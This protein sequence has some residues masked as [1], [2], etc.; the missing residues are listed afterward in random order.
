MATI[1]FDPRMLL[2]PKAAAQRSSSPRDSDS[3]VGS[4]KRR[5]ASQS[6]LS[7]SGK[8]A[9]AS[10]SFARPAA[11]DDSSH[12]P[13]MA[14]MMETMYNVAER[15]DLPRK[16]PKLE[17]NGQKV[18]TDF[19]GG[20]GGIVS[21][22]LKDTTPNDTEEATGKDDLSHHFHSG[23]GLNQLGDL[24]EKINRASAGAAEVVDLSSEADD[25]EL[26]P[27]ET[28]GVVDLTKDDGE[29]SASNDPPSVCF[30][31]IDGARVN[32]YK[33]PRPSANAVDFANRTW[34]PIKCKLQRLHGPSMKITVYDAIGKDFG[35]LDV[36]ASVA[37]A[38]V[39]DAKLFKVRTEARLPKRSRKEWEMPG[40]TCSYV[41]DISI[42][43][44]GPLNHAEAVG[45]FLSQK[46]VFLKRPGY[47]YPSMDYFNPHDRTK[48]MA[49]RKVNAPGYRSTTITR[50]TEETQND[51]SNLF[52]SI[53]N[54]DDIPEA[55][56][57][58]NVIT[59]LLQH[60]KQALHF[61]RSHEEISPNEDGS[62]SSQLLKKI[63]RANGTTA[64]LNLITDREISQPPP[65]VRGGILADMMGL[66]K[67]LSLLALIASTTAQASEWV[68]HESLAKPRIRATLL[69]CPLSVVHNWE[70]QIAAHIKADSLTAYVYHGSNRSS[71]PS[72]F[73]SV[74]III[75][76]YGILA[77][78]MNSPNLR[79]R[80][81]NPFERY[82][83]YRMVL[84]EAH[85]I[86]EQGTR[87]SQA[88]CRV[89]SFCR[90]ALTGTPI[91]N[92]LDDFGSLLK[93]L[94]VSPFED[95]SNFSRYILAP[96]KNAD[97][98][99]LMRLR[100]LVGS[101]MLRRTKEKIDLPK[102]VERVVRLEFSKDE[103][104]LYDAFKR[105]GNNRLNALSS[106]SNKLAGKAYRQVLR[107]ILILRLISAHGRELLNDEDF[108]VLKG[109][110][111]STAIDLDSE[112]DSTK[113]LISDRDAYEMLSLHQQTGTD[114]CARCTKQ[115]QAKE[116]DEASVFGYILTCYQLICNE[117][118]ES[119]KK[120]MDE[121]KRDER[122]VCLYC[123]EPIRAYL[124][125]LT[126]EGLER[127]DDARAKMHPRQAKMIGRYQ[128]PHTKVLAL[129]KD[130]TEF[131][132]HNRADDG[133]PIKSV[134]FSSWTTYLDLIEIPLRARGIQFTRL[135]GKMSRKD[136]TKSLSIF[137]DDR[138]TEIILVSLGAGGVGLNLTAGSRVYMMEPQ[139]NP[140]A[141][142]QAVDRVHRLGQTR[143]V[144]CTRFIM[145]NSI[146]EG[147]R[148]LQRKKSDL[149]ELSLGKGKVDRAEAAREKLENLKAL[150]R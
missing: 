61:L 143:D 66:G 108:E 49:P 72:H 4:P 77:S 104:E 41:A 12:Q 36:R 23:L 69:V 16:R 47:S 13:G 118:F 51:L 6:R 131:A 34:P 126:Q 83:F 27:E 21:Q 39:M 128:G 10:T 88:V 22:H 84:D 98:N 55:E 92:R 145:E 139:Y 15:Q 85:F 95:S 101:I 94:R 56:P 67:T 97:A 91:Q 100:L 63:Q 115:L 42:V 65:P 149:A 79:V 127:A 140:A 119:V 82:E 146:E 78:E 142:A 18:K 89:M 38:P 76:T 2:N 123:K 125:E 32:C 150:I 105:D 19:S 116:T 37:L 60:Q 28:A 130:L 43:L 33:V 30:G 44:Y 62:P 136:R 25:E 106:K 48:N 99:V 122:L 114:N 57:S 112:E 81:S 117:C 113:P 141:E 134:V 31:Q 75:T 26:S 121:R 111:S 103:K 5:S 40:A 58:E 24:A 93:F 107:S 90:W 45:R 80:T 120:E 8:S 1:K 147:I 3:V 71:D 29:D 74:D 17:A 46:N 9:L 87:T 70:E 96:F 137:S 132:E 73:G 20:K 52:D 102:R 109:L 138:A 35:L 7:D 14:N 148:E 68:A 59:Q 144:V 86:R 64:W 135:D 11:E 129:L 133:P 50:T 53:H 124:Q 54:E 110:S